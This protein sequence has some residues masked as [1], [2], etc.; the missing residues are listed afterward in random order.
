MSPSDF[1][2][3]STIWFCG[4]R[5][6][7]TAFDG[8]LHLVSTDGPEPRESAVVHD[9][10][11][12]GCFSANELAR[13]AAPGPWSYLM[14][15]FHTEAIIECPAGTVAELNRHWAVRDTETDDERRQLAQQVETMGSFEATVHV[16]ANGPHYRQALAK[17]RAILAE[18]V[19]DASQ[20]ALVVIDAALES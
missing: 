8:L 5:W 10:E 16:M 6:R 3:G 4:K 11:F 7:V 14:S 20:Q 9:Q 19:A 18:G 13:D 12:G 1:I 2:P 17:A 15:P